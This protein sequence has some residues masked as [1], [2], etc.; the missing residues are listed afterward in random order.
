MIF[1]S[2]DF[3]LFLPVVFCVYWMLQSNLDYF[4]GKN[5]DIHFIDTK[6]LLRP[7]LMKGEKDIYK[8]NDT[9]WN[10]KTASR[11]ACEIKRKLDSY[12]VELEKK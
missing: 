7:Y 6:V 5:N 2:L 8:C 4:V 3:M 12:I 9:H 11:V 10:I 1:N